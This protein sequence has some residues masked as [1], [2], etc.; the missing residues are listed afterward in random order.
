MNLLSYGEYAASVPIPT[1]LAE[2]ERFA[3]AIGIGELKEESG[4][5][6]ERTSCL[7]LIVASSPAV[8]KQASD[9]CRSFGN[10]FS[11]FSTLH[12]LQ[13]VRR[14]AIYA[15]PLDALDRSHALRPTMGT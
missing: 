4:E 10:R 6:H 14:A 11:D 12:R 2:R 15:T 5:V 3:G 7:A 9:A 8:E 1:Y 13:R